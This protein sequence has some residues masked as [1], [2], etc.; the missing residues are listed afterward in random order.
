VRKGNH[1]KESIRIISAPQASG[2]ERRA[3]FGSP[4]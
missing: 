2:K 3:Y 4:H 1:D